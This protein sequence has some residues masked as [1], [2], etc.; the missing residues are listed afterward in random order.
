MCRIETNPDSFYWSTRINKYGKKSLRRKSHCIS[1]TKEWKR[2]PRITNLR[3][4]Q[5]ALET[6]RLYKEH[7]R[8]K[9]RA[10]TK[11]YITSESGRARRCSA[12]TKRKAAQLHRTPKWA[13]MKEINKF[14]E[15]ASF[16]TEFF[17]QPIVVDHIIPLQGKEVSGL[18]VETNLQLLTRHEN[19]KKH[20][21]FN[22]DWEPRYN[23]FIG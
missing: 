2:Q 3:Y 22:G 6:S 8:E 1:C 5:K 11:E 4:R 15:A 23:E 18:H 20:N 14:Y 16:A 13:D 9:V 17:E 10:K 19:N 7:N 21:L 12:Q